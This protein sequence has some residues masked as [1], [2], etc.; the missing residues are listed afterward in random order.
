MKKLLFITI[1]LIMPMFMFGQSYSALWKKVQNAEEKDLPKTQYEVLQQIVNKAQKEKQ[2]G[3]LLKAELMGAQTMAAIAPDSLKPEINRIV[4]RYNNATDEALRLV[5]QTV[6]YQ[7]RDSQSR[8]ELDIKKPQLTPEVCKLLAKTKDKSYEPFVVMGVDAAVFGNDMLSVIGA[9]LG[10]YQELRDY[11]NSV[12]N[13]KAVSI[14]DAHLA[15]EQYRRMRYDTPVAERIAFIDDAIGKWG[16]WPEINELRNEKKRLTNSQFQLSYNLHMVRPNQEQKVT[17]MELR[18]L[19]SLTLTVYPVKLEGDTE[20]TPSDSRDWPKIQPLLGKPVMKETKQFGEHKPYEEFEDSLTLKGLPVGMYMVEMTTAPTTEVVRQL[21]HVTDMYTM[22]ETQPNGKIRYVVV[23]ATT[24]QP[25]AGAHLKIVER[26]AY[27]NE[28]TTNAVTN[29]KG[30]YFFETQDVTRYRKVFAY[31][32]TDKASIAL[33]GVGRYVFYD[34]D[35]TMQQRVIFTD[36]S[37][38]RPGQT[39]HTSALAYQVVHGIEQ[40]VCAKSTLKFEL[41]DANYKVVAEKQAETDEFGVAAVDFTLPSTGLTGVFTIHVDNN[42]HTIRVEEYKRPTFHVDFDEYK[43]AYKAGDTISVKGTAMS[44][45][46]VPVQDAKV[47]YKVMRRTAFWWWNYSRYYDE[48][49]LGYSS[50]GTEVYSGEATTDAEGNFTVQMPLTMPET[51]HAMFYN[52]VVMADVTDGA[53]ETHNGQMSLPLGNRTVALSIDIADKVL[54]EDNPVA[55]FHVRNAAGKDMDAEVKYR[56]DGGAWLS[57]KANSQLTIQNSQLLSGEHTIEAMFEDQTVIR[58]FVLFSLDDEKPATETDDWFYQSATQFPNDGTPVTIQVGSSAP[59]VHIVYSIF[60]GKKLIE[61]GAV[62]RSNQLI[63]RKFTY[64]DEYEN[65]LLLTY[66]WVKNGKCYS[67]NAT[68]MRPMPDKKLKLEW[69]TFRDRL[70]PGQKEEWT[71]TI[72]DADGKPVDANLMA[73]LYDQSLNQLAQHKWQFNPYLWIPL[74]ST[75]WQFTRPYYFAQQGSGSWKSLEVGDISFSHF[76]HNVYPQYFYTMGYRGSRM[77]LARNGMVEDGM[78]MLEAAPAMAPMEMMAETKVFDVVETGDVD[79]EVLKAKEA[80]DDAIVEVDEKQTAD[81][82]MRENLNETAFFYPQLTTDMNGRVAIKFTLP[83]SLTTWQLLGFAHTRELYYGNIEAEAVAKKDVMIQPNVPRFVREGDKAT[84]SARI[85]NTGEKA[86][87]GTARLVLINAETNAIIYEKTQNVSIK[88]GETL[89]VAF[90]LT[91]SL[92]TPSLLICKMTISGKGYS[93][94]EQHYLP[95][96]PASE[97]VTIALPITQHQPGTETI[98]LSKLVPA[99]AKNAKLTLEYTNNPVWLMIQALPSVGS[100]NED[101]AISLAASYY[102]NGI[103]KYIIDQNP[104][105]K[106]VFQQWMQEENNSQFTI[107][108][109]LSSQLEKNEDL[110]NLVLSE[111]PW[112]MDADKETEQKH[113]LAD[114]FDE[115][116]MNNRLD[117]CIEKLNKLQLSDGSWTWYPG[118]PGSFYMTVAV[119]EMLV[120]L[121]ALTAK[122]NDTKGMLNS[123]FNYMGQEIVDLVK[124]L[125]KAEKKGETVTFPSYKALQWLYLVTLDGRQLPTEVQNANNYL[126]ELLKKDIKRQSIYDKALSAVI[127]SKIDAQ[128]AQ[129][130]AQSLREYTVFSEDMGRYYDTPRAGY[131]WFD[132]KIP[133][134]SIAIEALQAINPNDFQT[135]DEMQRWLLQQKRTQAWDTPINSVN[136]VYAFL[137]GQEFR[138]VQNQKIAT[139]NLDVKTVALPKATAA[140]GYVKTVLPKGKRLTIRKT[141]DGTSWGAVYAQFFQP[142]K[143]VA[144]TGSGLT[145]K[146]ELMVKDG[147][148]PSPIT[149]HLSPGDRVTVRLTITADRDYDFVQVVDKRAACMEPVKQLSGY[150]H[151]GY[152]TPRDNTTCYFYDM[153]SKG[154]HVIETEYYIDRAGTYETGTATVECAYSPE[155][156]AVTKSLTLKIKD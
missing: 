78:V 130:Y 118:M 110:K 25:I 11:Y 117:K 16:K 140:I 154:T 144:D 62:E 7:I 52:F 72:K 102:A 60:S 55:T 107:H 88:A 89:P 137:K 5:Y 39:V 54:I 121:N 93:D 46:G 4:E 41:R 12:G 122:Q 87:K 51:Q 100:P 136:A 29:D 42:S 44:Y 109:S 149:H 79:G 146:R 49:S 84:I 80:I 1:A 21:Y 155:F 142:A 63:N 115:N 61:Q 86:V 43:E 69:A 24:G 83:E 13:Q 3:Q 129:E 22:A 108:N 81:V 116:L 133:T 76:D 40:T 143:N 156:R 38:Y 125:K 59:D 58:K 135:I 141:S 30:E 132:Y 23:N 128:R 2:Y 152:I 134:Q 31:T 36:R 85:S 145:I 91:P 94:G 75:S 9:E 37:I 148:N 113:R 112:V 48:G 77:K 73:T 45:A 74:P 147:N 96:L 18:N 50:N 106:P 8:I 103:G 150:H 151:G 90:E 64:K 33:R 15:V 66:A 34:A 65:G 67:H 17:L 120:R 124:E 114:F 105:I 98:D 70:T 153:L 82:Q 32:D 26:V 68:I 57:T 126:M 123:A 119:S 92:L 28:K 20:L 127:F 95:V 47:S 111:T 99:D 139:I 101:N 35:R 104:Q 97:R 138:L 131:S 19:S 10:Y 14:L 56:L 6:L 53:G 27:R 71:L